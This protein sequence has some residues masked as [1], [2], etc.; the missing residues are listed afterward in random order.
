MSL[1]H[2]RAKE[3][4][5]YDP[6]TG[7]LK[8]R[9]RP[10][11]FSKRKAG[12]EAGG[13]VQCGKYRSVCCEGKLYMVHR[14]AW[15]LSYGEWPKN[16]ID[17]INGD[18]CDNRLAN[19]RDATIKEN[20]RNRKEHRLGKPLFATYCRRN[21]RWK[22]QIRINGSLYYLGLHD[23]AEAAEAVGR[24][25]ET[26]KQASWMAKGVVCSLQTP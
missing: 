8:W 21:K 17:H 5:S 12:D 18:G 9:V 3:L 4:F 20:S 15:L 13:F 14:V 6:L 7:I 1:T 10:F 19:L 16:F 22:A 26:T 23:T 24:Q 11:R 25:F 2:E